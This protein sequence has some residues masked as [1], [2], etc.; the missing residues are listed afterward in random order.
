MNIATTGLVWSVNVH[1]V[2]RVT[3][4]PTLGY[5]EVCSGRGWFD[6]F[7]PVR[8]FLL[9]W[10]I[11]VVLVLVLALAVVAACVVAATFVAICH[12]CGCCFSISRGP[13]ENEWLIMK[14]P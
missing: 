6:C 3:H 7:L 5:V 10:T 14:M 12:Y 11:L 4:S 9:L 2:A 8:M 13:I 1:Q